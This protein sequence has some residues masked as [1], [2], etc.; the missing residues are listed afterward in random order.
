M[1]LFRGERKSTQ[2]LTFEEL[3]ALV[4]G[5]PTAAGVAVSPDSA[6]KSSTVFACCKVISE[7]VAQL[8]LHLFRRQGEVKE[9]AGDHRLYGVLHDAANPWTT[10][11]E[12]RGEM[13]LALLKHGHAFAFKNVVDGQVAELIQIANSAVG[14]ERDPLTQE[15]TYRVTLADGTTRTYT[16]AE[17]FHLRAL[18]GLAP[19]QQAR[20]AIGLDLALSEHASR[21]FANGARP[22]GVLEY[23]K[24]LG[25]EVVK[26]LRASFNDSHAGGANS[27]KTLVLEDGMTF[28]PLQFNSVDLQFLEMR[29][30]QVAEISRAFR[31]PLHLVNELERATHN[32]AESMGRQFLSLCLL[33]W[34]EAWEQGI[35][36]Q[37]LSDA[38]RATHYAEFQTDDLA[39][40]DLAQRFEAYAKAVQFGLL[41]P[42]EVRAAENRAPYEGGDRFRLPLNTEDANGGPRDG[43]A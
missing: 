35:K 18:G 5:G 19:V 12:F 31:I 41:S 43:A 30:H 14:V 15:P 21:L 1:T 7:S 32:N 39:R 26:R 29:R 40:A 27:G 36:L 11:T 23:G 10:A 17:I 9:R 25:A 8:P 42:N 38:D 2:S 24:T 20:E 33:P 22:S 34:L 28:K 6:L 13:T 16:R 4:G 37:L 3:V